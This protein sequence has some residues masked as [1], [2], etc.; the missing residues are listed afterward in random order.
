MADFQFDSNVIGTCTPRVVQDAE[1]CAGITACD[2]A[3]V[4]LDDVNTLYFDNGAPRVDTAI[5]EADFIG[6]VCQIRQNGMH[7]WLMASSRQWSRSMLGQT[8]NRNGRL[9]FE[10]FV[11]S[12]RK[13]LINSQ[14]W[15]A[16]RLADAAGGV[17][18]FKIVNS[19]GSGLPYG[20]QWFQPKMRFFAQWLK[21]GE[22]K[23]VQ[24]EIIDPQPAT[25]PIIDA[26]GMT[27]AVRI[28]DANAQATD[29]PAAGGAEKI[30]IARGTA[31]VA[32]MESYCPQDPILNTYNEAYYWTEH[33]RLSLCD[34]DLTQQYLQ[35]A[36]EGNPAYRKWFHVEEVERNRQSL[37]Q[38]QDR[39]AYQFFWGEPADAN[40]TPGLWRN[41]PQISLPNT[42]PWTGDKCVGRRADTVGIVRQLRECS[43]SGADIW[44]QPYY[45]WQG[46]PFSLPALFRAIYL[47][48]RVREENGTPA[49]MFELYTTSFMANQIQQGM[50]RYFSARSEGLLRMNMELSSKGQQGPFGFRF[51]EY[52]LDIPAGV[53][54][55]VMTH[56]F[57]DDYASHMAS[58]GYSSAG[59]IIAL[60]DW[61]S[62]YR[63]V[64][65]STRVQTRTGNVQQLALAGDLEAA[66][67][68]EVPQIQYT[69]RSALWAAV[70]ECPASSRWWVN[71]SCEV[72]SHAEVCP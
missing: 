44:E 53:R 24:M 40:Q 11:R 9:E 36:L 41:L 43:D 35:W 20:H 17:I 64:L 46:Q 18:V 56:R 19:S 71:A 55:R 7:D 28:R 42:G 45:D 65:E 26:T 8:A 12:G 63:A 51:R 48:Q 66:C 14:F 72:P 49:D 69:H 59:N 31:N 16:T 47:M 54:L 61:S 57:F 22:M 58:Q 21:A 4:T 60:I 50:I 27:Y 67:Q 70:Q 1:R 2:L 30:S 29:I 39:Q 23:S 34:N 62:T 68:M 33:T 32:N 5:K 38:W 37:Q 13:G 6:K 25:Y 15:G 10:P 3:P 52:E